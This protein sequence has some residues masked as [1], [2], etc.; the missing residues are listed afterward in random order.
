MKTI[1]LDNEVLQ[2]LY[3]GCE[4][5]K[6]EVFSEFISSYS[7]LKNNLVTVYAS[8]NLVS[9]KSTLHYHGPSFMYLGAP[10]VASMFK[11]LELQ[12]GVS[13][14][15][16]SISAQFNELLEMVE[17]TWLQ[18]IDNCKSYKKAV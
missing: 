2:S 18:V 11:K 8:G 14:S 15:T 16:N 12:C 13:Q 6:E 5:S 10:E 4:E 7:D 17:A 9:I 1:Q 3:S